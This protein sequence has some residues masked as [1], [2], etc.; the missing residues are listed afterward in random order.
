M[1]AFPRAFTK[2]HGL[3]NDFIVFEAADDAPLPDAAQ[4]RRLA[5]RHAGIGFDQAFVVLPPRSAG[6][7]AYWRIFNADG[8]EVEQCGNGARCVAEWLRLAGRAGAVGGDD[9]AALRLESLGGIIAARFPS[10]GQVAI[11]MGVPR[12]TAPRDTDGAA[13]DD[14][15]LDHELTVEGVTVRF[16]QVSIGNPHIVLQVPSV[17]TAPVATL[18][19]ALERHPMFPQRTNVGFLEVIDRSHGRL[20]VFERGVGETLACGTGACGAAAAGRRAGLFDASVTLTLRGG[21][22]VIDW[23]GGDAPLWMTGPAAV[24]FRGEIDPALLNA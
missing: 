7:D 11:D 18:G 21:D 16:T 20:R 14:L 5:D 4:W 3:G 23:S 12:F 2:M 9:D 15:G 8:G 6:T 1:D 13:A 17:D 22:L 19:P 10:P 24:A